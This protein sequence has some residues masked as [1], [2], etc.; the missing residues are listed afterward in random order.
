MAGSS[1]ATGWEGFPA[2]PH[3]FYRQALERASTPQ[4]LLEITRRAVADA[5]KGEHFARIFIAKAFGFDR[6][7]ITLA[8]HPDS[9]APVYHLD[10][11]TDGELETLGRLSAKMLSGPLESEE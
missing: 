7:A 5:K 9:P 4:D 3:A 2:S 6:L 10:A 11:L 8:P 1:R